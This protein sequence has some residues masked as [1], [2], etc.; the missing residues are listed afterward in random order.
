MNKILGVMDKK[1][2]KAGTKIHWDNPNPYMTMDSLLT[3]DCF[4][5]NL[6]RCFLRKY[7]FSFTV[8]F[9]YTSFCSLDESLRVTVL[10]LDDG[11]PLLHDSGNNFSHHSKRQE[12]KGERGR[13]DNT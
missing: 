5:P 6:S 11:T 13:I 12:K 1:S 3:I 7:F 8:Q 4:Q 9:R 10:T 2:P